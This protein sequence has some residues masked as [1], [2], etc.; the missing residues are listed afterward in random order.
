M[1]H[2]GGGVVVAAA[3]KVAV[4]AFF[5]DTISIIMEASRYTVL[6][7][8]SKTGIAVLFLKYSR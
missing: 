4:I 2:V 7:S 1:A 3:P 5:S 6:A 8:H